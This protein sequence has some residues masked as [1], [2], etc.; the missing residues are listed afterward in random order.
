MKRHYRIYIVDL[1]QTVSL[2]DR[3]DKIICE[4]RIVIV[5]FMFDEMSND[6]ANKRGREIRA[7]KCPGVRVCK[8]MPGIESRRSV[9]M[10]ER[11]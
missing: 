5:C 2:Q 11:F 3:K 10:Q 9:D 7:P 6:C 1:H 4:K 8:S